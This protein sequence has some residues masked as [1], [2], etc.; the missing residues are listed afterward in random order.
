M[1]EDYEMAFPLMKACAEQGNAKAQFLL[2]LMYKDGE[3]TKPDQVAYAYWLGELV[4]SAERGDPVA[5]WELSCK[6]RW[7]NHFL[8]DVCKANN[9]L[10]QAAENGNGDA[11][12]HLAHYLKHGE[13][14]LEADSEKARFWFM[15]AFEQEYPEALYARSIELL[16]VSDKA[17]V[18]PQAIDL[19]KKAAN[20]D[21]GPAK[22][23]LADLLH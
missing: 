19:L 15:R 14:G 3:G 18:L 11:Q 10:E 9:W 12:F 7:G 20:Q 21:F 16:E 2:A 1:A 8:Q 6:L 22:E 4:K 23:L 5:Q 17:K 13:Y